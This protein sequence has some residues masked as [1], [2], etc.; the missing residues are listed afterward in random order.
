MIWELMKRIWQEARRQ[1]KKKIKKKT[2]SYFKEK[3]TRSGNYK[4]KVQHL[5][6]GREDCKAGHKQKQASIIFQ[7][8]AKILNVK[9]YYN[10]G[11]KDLLCR[12]CKITDET[13]Q[14]ILEE[15]WGLHPDD[16]T[17]VTMEDL[18]NEKKTKLIEVANKMR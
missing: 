6:E 2:L 1:Q 3:I 15:C 11:K 5:L 9:N 10:K 14:Y 8:R 7:G 18:F 13:K 12:I 16:S 17:K 4:M